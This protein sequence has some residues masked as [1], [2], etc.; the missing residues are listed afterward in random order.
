MP[1]ERHVVAKT[2][3]R[4][5]L[6]LSARLRIIGVLGDGTLVAVYSNVVAT[7]GE[8]PTGILRSSEVV[9]ML[10]SSGAVGEGMDEFRS[11]SSHLRSD[12]LCGVSLVSA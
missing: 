7:S 12:N 2:S 1:S 9:G 6:P 4:Y 8:I 11:P 5:A 3:E 10:D